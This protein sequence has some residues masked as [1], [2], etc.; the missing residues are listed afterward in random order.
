MAPLNSQVCIPAP[1]CS[2]EWGRGM[3]PRPLLCL[4]G[5]RL[6]DSGACSCGWS[7]G[8][9]SFGILW[10]WGGSCSKHAAMAAWQAML[11]LPKINRHITKAHAFTLCES[12]AIHT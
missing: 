9:G 5:M 12:I 11:L 7:R 4:V 1:R 3:P 8:W 10:F 6:L 2:D